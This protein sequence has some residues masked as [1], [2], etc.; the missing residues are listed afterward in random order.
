M[1][2]GTIC[3]EAMNQVSE[4]GRYDEHGARAST[5]F[6]KKPMRTQKQ[7]EHPRGEEYNTGTGAVQAPPRGRIQHRSRSS[8]RTT[9]GTSDLGLAC[10]LGLADTAVGFFPFTL[11]T[12]MLFRL[13][14]TQGDI[15]PV[16]HEASHQ[17]TPTHA[18]MHTCIHTCTPTYTHTRSHRPT[19]THHQIITHAHTITATHMHTPSHTCTTSPT[20]MH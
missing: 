4:G 20:H 10:I 3:I 8:K 7:Y 6:G 17:I 19:R 15:W 2:V 16:S 12:G 14:S 1:V 5:P 11:T 18:H 9:E 13:R